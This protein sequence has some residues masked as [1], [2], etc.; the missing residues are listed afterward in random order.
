ML[1]PSCRDGLINAIDDLIKKMGRNRDNK[2]DK[3]PP[4]KNRRRRNEERRSRPKNKV[5]KENP[6]RDLEDKKRRTG[7]GGSDDGVE[8]GEDW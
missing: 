4:L 7:R 8:I 3:R 2:I 5:E 6:Q 1:I